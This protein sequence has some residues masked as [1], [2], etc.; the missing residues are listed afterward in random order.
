MLWGSKHFQAASL[1]KVLILGVFIVYF[2]VI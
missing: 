1:S 2:N